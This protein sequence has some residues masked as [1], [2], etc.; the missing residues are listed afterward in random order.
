MFLNFIFTFRVGGSYI[1]GGWTGSCLTL[2]RNS[3]L[4]VLFFGFF[5]V[6]G[7]VGFRVSAI[8]LFGFV[9][10]FCFRFY[11]FRIVRVLF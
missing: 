7:V 5:E 9:S 4:V 10:R 1:G 2:Y 8:F 3:Y 11:V 6:S